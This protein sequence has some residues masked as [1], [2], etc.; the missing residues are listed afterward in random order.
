MCSSDLSQIQQLEQ[1]LLMS[2]ENGD[3]Q[4]PISGTT[5]SISCFADNPGGADI[6]GSDL[7]GA[8]TGGG[9]GSGGGTG[10]N[11]CEVTIETLDDQLLEGPYTKSRLDEGVLRLT[12]TGSTDQPLKV[13]LELTGS[14]TPLLDYRISNI[15]RK[16]T[17]L[18]SS[19]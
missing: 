17:R 8:D 3:G 6:G 2:G 13:K 14:A 10:D 1:R 11:G 5:G 19:H 12:R 9:T 18:N 15:D 16:S 7:G 4:D